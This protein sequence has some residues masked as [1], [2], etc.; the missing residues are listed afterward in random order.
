M[1]IIRKQKIRPRWGFRA[2]ALG[3]AL[4]LCWGMGE[5]ATRLVLGRRLIIEPFVQEG[6]Y[7]FLPNQ[8]G[9]YLHHLRAAARINNIGAR[10]ADV[11]LT[12]LPTTRKVVF[13]GDSF[14]FG[15]ALQENETLSHAFMTGM[16]LTSTAV[17]NFGNSAFGIPHMIAA[18]RHVRHLLRAGDTVVMTMIE[19]DFYRSLQAFSPSRFGAF[20]WW[21]RERSA[22]LAW[23]WT[24]GKSSVGDLLQRA[25]AAVFGPPPSPAPRPAPAA[26]FTGEPG[27]VLA[28]FHAE[29]AGRGE[30]VLYVFHEYEP[31]EYSRAAA[32]FCAAKRLHCVT[33]VP[34]ILAAV[35]RAGRPLQTYDRMHP[36]PDANRALGAHLAGAWESFWAAPKAVAVGGHRP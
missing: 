23:A 34:V 18:Y 15:Y 16:G 33:D 5:V 4:A 1:D 11:D 8:E 12:L 17:L 24:A 29:L 19:D 36:S 26:L 25:R 3:L 31:T 20:C 22:F 28:D 35:R 6:F 10:G 21:V 2:A 13:L 7:R 30:R 32:Q 9:W 27:T 14:T